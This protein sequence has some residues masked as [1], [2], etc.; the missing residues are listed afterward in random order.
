MNLA[1]NP[2]TCP[3]LCANSSCIYISRSCVSE[4]LLVHYMVLWLLFQ[5]RGY[6]DGP[7]RSHFAASNMFDNPTATTD[8]GTGTTPVVP[9]ENQSTGASVGHNEP[10]GEGHA[11]EV[12]SKP[13]TSASV[14]YTNAPSRTTK[15]TTQTP[16]STIAIKTTLRR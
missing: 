9:T 15:A 12:V 2:Y 7:I 10:V 6:A 3:S 4:Q 14:L 11:V 5:G 8:Q 16:L 13:V 1:Y